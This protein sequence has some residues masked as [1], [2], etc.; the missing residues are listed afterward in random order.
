MTPS[1]PS[2]ATW[3]KLALWFGRRPALWLICFAALTL[4][5]EAWAEVRPQDLP[6]LLCFWDF[7]EKGADRGLTSQGRYAYT[8][9]EMNGRTTRSAE[10]VFGA[11]ALEIK[12]GQ[13]LVIKREDCPGLNIHGQR[14]VSMVAWIN[15]REDGIWQYIAG[16]WNE[17]RA[18]RQY[19]LFTAGHKQ[20]DYR[21][22]E[23]I[24]AKLQT[25]GYVSDLGGATEGRP[26]CFS[27]ATGKTRL[28]KDR[29]HMIAFTYDHKSIRVYV[30]GRLD[31]NTTY[32]PFLW[33]K[34]IFD[35]GDK[36]SEFTV[37]QRAL[38]EW[39]GYPTVEA[40][41]H[42]QGFSGSLGGLAVYDRAL[43]PTEI[44]GLYRS[45]LGQRAK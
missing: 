27:Y 7:Q 35:G 5:R 16:M 1:L 22:L 4:A 10:G 14:Q 24:D 17:L 11:T 9:E 21:T 8:L 41:T 12:K 2:P 15:R 40:P 19:A 45:T 26:F 23:R 42:N 30:D 36:G 34:P 39:P 6:N 3:S 13:W 32:N 25:H 38:P 37:A 33:D 20:T 29:W 31:E 43:T 44:E 28:E 18:K